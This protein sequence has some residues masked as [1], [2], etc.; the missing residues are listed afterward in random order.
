MEDHRRPFSSNSKWRCG[1]L[2][3]WARVVWI[4]AL[5][6]TQLWFQTLV[7]A[8]HQSG[9][10]Y[11]DR[12]LEAVWVFEK[13]LYSK[14]IK[15]YHFMACEEDCGG[16]SRSK[17]IVPHLSTLETLG[18]EKQQELRT[19]ERSKLSCCLRYFARRNLWNFILWPE[20]TRTPQEASNIIKAE[21]RTAQTISLTSTKLTLKENMLNLYQFVTSQPKPEF[22]QSTNQMTNYKLYS[23]KTDFDGSDTSC[24]LP[25]SKSAHPAVTG[26]SQQSNAITLATNFRGRS[27]VQM[28]NRMTAVLPHPKPR[29]STSTPSTP[30]T[31]S[32]PQIWKALGRCRDMAGEIVEAL[33]MFDSE[34]SEFFIFWVLFL[35]HSLSFFVIL[36]V[37]SFGLG[38][39]ALEDTGLMQCHATFSSVSRQQND[40]SIWPCK[41]IMFSSFSECIHHLCTIFA[42]SPFSS[43]EHLPTHYHCVKVAEL[44]KDGGGWGW[45]TCELPWWM[46]S[47]HTRYTMLAL[48][49]CG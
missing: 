30:S 19:R 7:T 1:R 33:V 43:L 9:C 11:V 35:C 4:K 5:P 16:E 8:S 17:T 6:G 39:W 34:G 10:V 38:V 24:R 3:V 45:W 15:I 48:L 42:A 27:L 13:I 14:H 23:L 32:H 2:V 47:R 44:I 37:F 49:W 36:P 28:L 31:P 12:F 20:G 46:Q 25:P 22:S 40:S 26:E 21:F 29:C 41:F 18:K